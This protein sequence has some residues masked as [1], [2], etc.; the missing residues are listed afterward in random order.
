MFTQQIAA[1]R[2]AARLFGIPSALLDEVA[3]EV[4]VLAVSRGDDLSTPALA[5]ARLVAL[6]RRVS[7][8]FRDE[9]PPEAAAEPLGIAGGEV[10]ANF[11]GGLDPQRR[12]V[13]VLTEVGGLSV[14][15]V[16]A[17][18]GIG[19]DAARTLW[20]EL[21]R[22]FAVATASAGVEEVIHDLVTALDPTPEKVEAQLAALAARLGPAPAPAA[23]PVTPPPAQAWVVP[24]KLRP[25]ASAGAA[26]RAEATAG[27]AGS[28]AAPAAVGPAP[29]PAPQPVAPGP[30]GWQMPPGTGSSGQVTPGVGA[31]PSVAPGVGSS[32]QVPPVAGAVPS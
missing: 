10:L 22:D 17:E 26:A 9:V 13:F 12:E 15:E 20:V 23:T 25:A 29:P 5:R 7:E 24:E 1:V 28:P 3:Q 8:W 19:F 11:V 32:G 16:S 31:V 18:L 21:V 6:T 4:F 2:A 30:V 14:P 27:A